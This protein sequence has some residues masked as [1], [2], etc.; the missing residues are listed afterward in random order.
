MGN[1]KENEKINTSKTG[2]PAGMSET[3]LRCCSIEKARN[4]GT[5]SKNVF[6]INARGQLAKK[7]LV[8]NENYQTIK[9][10]SNSNDKTIETKRDS[11][12][13]KEI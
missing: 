1:L 6:S 10:Y 4:R 13:S 5:Q 3:T 8:E 11:K 7:M 2:V 12:D 9:A